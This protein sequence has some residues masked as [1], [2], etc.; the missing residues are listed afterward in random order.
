[1]AEGPAVIVQD[2]FRHYGRDLRPGRGGRWRR[3][4]KFAR[5]VGLRRGILLID[6]QLSHNAHA[7]SPEALN[8][9]TT[10]KNCSK[11]IPKLVNP[12]WQKTQP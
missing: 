2:L 5:F 1:M 9:V 6:C 12:S 10:A 4:R 7:E 8:V 11:V 3:R